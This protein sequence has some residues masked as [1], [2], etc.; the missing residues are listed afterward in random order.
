MR[1]ITSDATTIGLRKSVELIFLTV[2]S[3]W[4]DCLK[5][6]VSTQ[7]Q[8]LKAVLSRTFNVKCDEVRK[9]NNIRVP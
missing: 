8:F 6:V 5:S 1:Y 7:A 2:V 9:D 4:S 3:E